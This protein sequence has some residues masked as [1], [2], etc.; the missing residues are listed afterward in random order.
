L[1]IILAF[2]QIF[3]GSSTGG[4]T[5]SEIIYIGLFFLTL[6][7]WL[8]THFIIRKDLLKVIIDIIFNKLCLSICLLFLYFLF[9]TL[10]GL[11]KGN[12]LFTEIRGWWRFLSLLVAILIY[13]EINSNKQISL[14]FFIIYSIGV[15]ISIKNLY[16]AHIWIQPLHR[17]WSL[18]YDS[19]LY[20]GS[21]GLITGYLCLVKKI[22]FRSLVLL[23]ISFIFIFLRMVFA[24]S[25]GICGVIVAMLIS[26]FLFSIKQKNI[27]FI[28]KRLGLLVPLVVFLIAIFPQQI[29]NLY[30]F[31]FQKI[32]LGIQKRL[33]EYKSAI[34]AG[35]KNPLIGRGFSYSIPVYHTKKGT[36]FRTQLNLPRHTYVHNFILHFFVS[37]GFIGLFLFLYIFFIF[38]KSSIALLLQPSLSDQYKG[39]VFGCILGVQNIL[40]IA[41][42]QTIIARQDTNFFLGFVFG[43]C[44]SLNKLIQQRYL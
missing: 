43:I 2:F 18:K 40:L 1:I 39:I 42:T 14:L 26:I 24:F 37:S 29:I 6:I 7:L 22:N 19:M 27:N 16:S 3:L 33:D 8:A 35:M 12:A 20:L 25:R 9:L 21:L 34:E 10:I 41:L 23:F 38:F 4:V 30:K 5:S 28:F 31:R 15:I 32:D 11:T 36:F 13:I 44:M 17:L